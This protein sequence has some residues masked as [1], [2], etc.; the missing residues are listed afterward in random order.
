[1]DEIGVFC[2]VGLVSAIVVGS[3]VLVWF[4]FRLKA[5]TDRDQIKFERKP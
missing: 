2:V 1:V 5:I 3:A 4:C